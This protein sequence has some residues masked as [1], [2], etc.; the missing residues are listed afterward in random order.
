[1]I[2]K[3][4]THSTATVDTIESP[5]SESVMQSWMCALLGLVLAAALALP[6]N[7]QA[8]YT[9]PGLARVPDGTV[10]RLNETLSVET[11]YRIYIQNGRYLARGDVR[12]LDPYCY[13]YDRQRNSRS[14]PPFTVNAGDFDVEGLD[15]RRYIVDASSPDSE[16]KIAAFGGSFFGDG[17]QFTLATEFFLT[18]PS[19]QATTSLICGIW[20]D[21]RERSFLTFDEISETLGGIVSIE[22]PD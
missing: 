7:A 20:A 10:F 21:P 19:S 1:M 4:T 5:L 17:S 14:E 22:L 6:L 3:A 12:Q 11:G 9:G 2:E 8:F 13:F 15:R 18:E 16:L